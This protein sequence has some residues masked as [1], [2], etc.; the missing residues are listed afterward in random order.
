MFV[1]NSTRSPT[2]RYNDE[3]SVFYKVRWAIPHC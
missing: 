2:W 1:L 3:I